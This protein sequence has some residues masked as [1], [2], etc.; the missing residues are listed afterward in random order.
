MATSVG[1]TV[2]LCV[3][4]VQKEGRKE[5]SPPPL[6]C[7]CQAAGDLPSS[8]AP[9]A[10]CNASPHGNTIQLHPR[11]ADAS[12]HEGQ[13]ARTHRGL[14]RGARHLLQRGPSLKRNTQDTSPYLFE[15]RLQ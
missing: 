15:L 1:R 7:S 11:L 5:G 9:G 2:Q 4:V 8:L 14:V 10:P 12:Q 3:C 13:E 6:T